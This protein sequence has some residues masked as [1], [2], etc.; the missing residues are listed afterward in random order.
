M[1][2]GHRRIAMRMVLILGVMM[3]AN[4]AHAQPQ[5]DWKLVIHGG[6]GVIERTQITPQKDKEIRA[7]LDHALATG[8]RVLDSG[9]SALDAVEATA[10]ELEDNAN[11][12]AGR[13]AVFTYDGTIEL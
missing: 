10:R 3:M 7:A 6:A 4:A 8:S 11:F 13:G 12:N 9:G 5:R 2:A 1:P